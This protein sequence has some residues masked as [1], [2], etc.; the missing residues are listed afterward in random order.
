MAAKPGERKTQKDQRVGHLCRSKGPNVAR[1]LIL[2]P[3][4]LQR[5][6][7][8]VQRA[9]TAAAAAS[10]GA[11]EKLAAPQQ[12]APQLVE[13]DVQVSKGG[14]EIIPRP[15]PC[16]APQATGER[17]SEGRDC[18][19]GAGPK[20]RR[21]GRGRFGALPAAIHKGKRG[22][23]QSLR[24]GPRGLRVGAGLL[25][26]VAQGTAPRASERPWKQ[27][28]TVR[29]TDTSS[30]CDSPKH[31]SRLRARALG[32]APCQYSEGLDSS[33]AF[34]SEQ[35]QAAR[36]QQH[37]FARGAAQPPGSQSDPGILRRSNV[38]SPQSKP[39]RVRA[40]SMHLMKDHAARIIIG[41]LEVTSDGV[42][43]HL[44]RNTPFRS[45]LPCVKMDS[46]G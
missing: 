43:A 29:Q 14:A 19:G 42:R 3:A 5:P 23:L 1:P 16:P 46:G 28:E 32:C 17:R 33:L 9:A 12:D 22:L 11:A 13:L 18:W 38:S 26:A 10:G 2:F 40:Q 36:S 6:P 30:C 34:P 27:S 37:A 20:P 44:P 35:A 21:G 25:I 8:E 45:P 24:T 31:A 7:A 15:A 39:S 41:G 4:P